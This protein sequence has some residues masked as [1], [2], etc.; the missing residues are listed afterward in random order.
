MARFYS[1]HIGLNHVDSAHY[2]GWTGA[3]SGCEND[4]RYFF[5]L[6]RQL[7][8]AASEVLLTEHATRAALRALLEEYRCHLETGDVFFLTYSGHGGQVPDRSGDEADRLDETWCLYDGQ[9]SDDELHQLLRAF[10]PGVQIFVLSDSC[11]SGS[12]TRNKIPLAAVP[13]SYKKRC[14]PRDVADLV[15]IRN[16]PDYDAK[17]VMHPING[18]LGAMVHLWA[19]CADDQLAYDTGEY[20]LFTQHIKNTLDTLGYSPPLDRLMKKVASQMP[21]FQTP[22]Y[23]VLYNQS[24]LVQSCTPFNLSIP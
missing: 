6:S 24:A 1:A 13:L 4:A 8:Y 21:P 22:Q 15:Y 9:L 14:L 23:S 19:A 3:L 12:V 11:H 5:D 20:G 18:S 2:A 16:R 10:T 17:P 7:G